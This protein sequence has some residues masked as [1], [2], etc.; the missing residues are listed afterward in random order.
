M[1]RIPILLTACLALSGCAVPGDFCDVVPGPKVFA[2]ETAVAM[3]R[4]DR[5]ATE[6]I[7]IENEYGARFCAW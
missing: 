4:T 7:A 3:V 1:K 2:R 6:Q 5:G